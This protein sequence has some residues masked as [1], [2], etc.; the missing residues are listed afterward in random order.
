MSSEDHWK[1]K[2]TFRSFLISSVLICLFVVVLLFL[3]DIASYYATVNGIMTVSPEA[4]QL[5]GRESRSR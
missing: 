3:L 2:R 5:A 1:D 4:S